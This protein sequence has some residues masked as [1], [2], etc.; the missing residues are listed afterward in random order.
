LARSR[1]TPAAFAQRVRVCECGHLGKGGGGCQGTRRSSPRLRGE[2]GAAWRR[3][4]IRPGEGAFRRAQTRGG[5][6]SSRPSPRTA[7]RRSE[8]PCV[9]DVAALRARDNG[10]G[11]TAFLALPGLDPGIAGRGRRGTEGNPVSAR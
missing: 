1:G 6:P 4:G 3:T 7:G 9:P 10:C 8:R 5:A 2:G 11:H